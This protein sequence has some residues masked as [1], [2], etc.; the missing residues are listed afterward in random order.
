MPIG[1]ID[2]TK[3]IEKEADYFLP[4]EQSK[5]NVFLTIKNNMFTSSAGIDESNGGGYYILWPRDSQRTANEIRVY[6]TMRFKRKNIGVIITDSKSSPFRLG[7]TGTALAHSGFSALKNYIGKPDIF[8][9]KLKMTR[10]N[11]SEG[12]AAAAVLGMGEGNEQT[13]LALI[14]DIPFIR[15]QA[16][17]PSSREVKELSI[18]PKDDLYASLLR[19]VFWRKGRKGKG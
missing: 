16:R 19:G 10:A 6:L 9:R 8:G 7:A 11:I 5:Y 12:L 15:F 17:S 18:D 4:R 1:S 2:K 14:E 13:P 3:L